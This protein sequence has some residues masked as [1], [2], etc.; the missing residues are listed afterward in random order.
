MRVAEASALS[1]EEIARRVVAG[2][3]ALFELIMRRHNQRVYRAVRSIIRDESEIED[4]MQQAYVLAYTHL[5]QFAGHAR[6]S[7]WLVRIAI[8][9][10]LARK[11]RARSLVLV[12][13]P[14]M[15]LE[16]R[17]TLPSTSESPESETAA[18]E[19]AGLIEQAVADLPD[20]YRTTFVLREIEG[21]TTAEAAEVQG[22][23]EDVV[24]QRLHRARA[25]VHDRLAARADATLAHTFR[26]GAERCD[27]IVSA[28]M[29]KIERIT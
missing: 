12:E 13:D 17:M 23:S 26:F 9:E 20:T 14:D 5:H 1:D 27:R 11:R 21:M 18:R 8:N 3:R 19:L 22:T 2:D 15:P 24:K 7:T 25:F 10:A 29:T 28:V 16:S 4:V 6:L